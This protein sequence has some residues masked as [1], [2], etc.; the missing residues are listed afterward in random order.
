MNS[1][2]VRIADQLRR[3]FSGDPWH[4]SPLRDLLAD[5]TAEQARMRPLP[6]AHN[7]WELVLHI[8]VYVGATLNAINGVAMPHL[9]GTEKDW[10]APEVDDKAW[11]NA[12][13]RLFHNAEQ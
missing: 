1:E 6:S 9:F 8:D 13:D 4:G 3:A 12:K 2:C 7:I 11:I 10:P 5:I